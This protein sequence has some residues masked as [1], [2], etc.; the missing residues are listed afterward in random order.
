MVTNLK[1]N[2][3]HESTTIYKKHRAFV[4]NRK[5]CEYLKSPLNIKFGVYSR[6]DKS[7]IFI[8]SQVINRNES[9]F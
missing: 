9:A 8:F 3:K 6:K 4:P 2:E 7:K 1:L 5:F